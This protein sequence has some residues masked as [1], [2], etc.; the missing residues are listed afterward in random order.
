LANFS[1]TDTRVDV[2]AV[3]V[4]GQKLPAQTVRVPS[5]GVLAVDVTARVPLD[6][7]FAVVADVRAVDGRRVPVVA[8]LL[9]TWSPTSPT[10]G[11][12]GA[13]GSTVTAR[14]WVVPQPD[15]DADSMVTVFNPGPGPVTATLLPAGSVDRRVG[16]TSEPELAIPAG[17]AKT[18]RLSL[19]GSSSP[20]A[21][22][23]ANGPVVVGLTVLGNAGAAISDGIPDLT[24]DG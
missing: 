17:E 15:V 1:D 13:V 24:Y 9:A 16:P 14:R 12:A 2:T 7:A 5:Q 4:S 20:P 18:F 21:V 23:T 10:T 3:T 22:V 19:L 6:T 8:E 11:L